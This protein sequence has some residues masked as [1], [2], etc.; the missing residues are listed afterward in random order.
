MVT[1]V[2]CRSTRRRGEVFARLADELPGDEQ[3]HVTLIGGA[4]MALGYESRRTTEDA[5]VVK[6]PQ[7]IASRGQSDRR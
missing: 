5:N 2:V 3:R 4:A 1:M 6:L 7:D